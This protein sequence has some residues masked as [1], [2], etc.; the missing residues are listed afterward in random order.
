[1]KPGHSLNGV[2]MYLTISGFTIEL[3]S[4]AVCRSYE[5][6]GVTT[7]IGI[8]VSVLASPLPEGPVPFGL[9]MCSLWSGVEAKCATP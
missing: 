9:Q 1:M 8:Y 5:F 3:Y 6:N 7:L 4:D 2:Y